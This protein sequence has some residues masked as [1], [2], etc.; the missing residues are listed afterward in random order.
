MH[1]IDRNAHVA[2]TLRSSMLNRCDQRWME[3]STCVRPTRKPRK[4][5]LLGTTL[6]VTAMVGVLVG[7][8]AIVTSFF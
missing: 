5:S 1:Y 4:P 2:Q 3:R 6:V 7:T 8:V